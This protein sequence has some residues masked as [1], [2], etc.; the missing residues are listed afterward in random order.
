[1]DVRHAEVLDHY[2]IQRQLPWEILS[3]QIADHH[4]HILI[5]DWKSSLFYSFFCSC[6]WGEGDS[7]KGSTVSRWHICSNLDHKA[8]SEM[9]SQSQKHGNHPSGAFSLE[10][11]LN[12]NPVSDLPQP[13][14]RSFSRIWIWISILL[15]EPIRYLLTS[16]CIILWVITISSSMCQLHFSF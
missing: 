12:Q 10:M 14:F 7:D 1:M 8:S 4:Q 15:F 16:I 5:T 3:I 6:C 11:A 2:L 13:P 9:K